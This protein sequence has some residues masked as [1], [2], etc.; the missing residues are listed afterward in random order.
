MKQN[1]RTKYLILII[2]KYQKA[3]KSKK[4]KILNE[5]VTDLC[6]NR[7][8]VIRLLNQNDRKKKD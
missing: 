5:L 6:M 3:D 7:K 1:V 2:A 8:S 4:K